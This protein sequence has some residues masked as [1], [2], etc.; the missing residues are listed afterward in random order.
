[1]DSRVVQIVRVKRVGKWTIIVT[2]RSAKVDQDKGI[3]SGLIEYCYR[4][5][6]QWQGGKWGWWTD[7]LVP[8]RIETESLGTIV[9]STLSPDVNVCVIGCKA[10]ST[11]L[12][13]N[14]TSMTTR[15]RDCFV[16]RAPWHD[17]QPTC[18]S[19]HGTPWNWIRLLKTRVGGWKKEN[20]F[21]LTQDSFRT[22]C[23]RKRWGH[24]NL[25]YINQTVI[26]VHASLLSKNWYTFVDDVCRKL[27]VVCVADL[28]FIVL[29]NYQR[30]VSV[31]FV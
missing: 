22:L 5:Q 12:H 13:N 29:P 4:T 30:L 6:Y 15:F 11:V 10:S 9:P 23:D 21:S 16:N 26:W 2:V 20:R 28:I 3:L 31:V 18:K 25:I 27:E 17:A 1:V 7:V 8:D 19:W 14:R 24:Q